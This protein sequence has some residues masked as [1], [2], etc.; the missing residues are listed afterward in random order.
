MTYLFLA[1]VS[2]ASISVFMR[3]SRS[4]V[5]NEMGLLAINYLICIFCASLYIKDFSISSSSFL[6]FI[7]GFFYWISF[8]LFNQS[9]QRNGLILSST[10]QKLGILI[11]TL[12]TICVFKEL[13]SWIQLLGVFLSILC[14]FILQSP[15]EE[16]N[17]H[18]LSLLCLLLI[19]NGSGDAMA[20]IFERVG[21]NEN[22]F[23]WI[24]FVVAFFLCFLSN[25]TEI[26]KYEIGFGVLIGIP[27]YFS[28]KFLL[29]S[30]YTLPALIVYPS[31]SVFTVFLVSCFGVFIFKEKISKKQFG[32]LI[33][34]LLSLIFL[35]V[36]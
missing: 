20:K 30:L 16:Q 22:V 26:T 1:I 21:Q 27:N 33:G 34:F 18:S 3:I 5:N 35:N 12:I 14:I 32:V 8:V 11:P 15:S 9:I 28:A 4:Y 36:K 24:T 25:K 7:N 10:F 2:S 13:N 19:F 6:G 17:I 29:K 31:Y 23:L